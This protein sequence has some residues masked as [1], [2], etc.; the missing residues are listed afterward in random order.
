MAQYGFV[1]EHFILDTFES[2]YSIRTNYSF[3]C[4]L[5]IPSPLPN[6]YSLSWVRKILSFKFLIYGVS[7]KPTLCIFAKLLAKKNYT[8]TVSHLADILV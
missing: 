2:M 4:I 6:L 5:S 1:K 3:C 8:E 7:H